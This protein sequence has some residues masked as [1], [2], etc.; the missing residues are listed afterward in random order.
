M[1]DPK[2]VWPGSAPQPRAETMARGRPQLL[3]LSVPPPRLDPAPSPPRQATTL[4]P[5]P[6]FD[7]GPHTSLRLPQLQSVLFRGRETRGP[8]DPRNRTHGEAPA[9]QAAPTFTNILLPWAAWP[10]RVGVQYT[11]M[12]FRSRENSR[13]NSFRIS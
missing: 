4:V 13:V 10:G 8:R 9:S 5:G 2:V 1:G 11:D 6:L 7:G 12:D 3:S